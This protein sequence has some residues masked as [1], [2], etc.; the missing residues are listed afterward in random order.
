MLKE[1]LLAEAQEL[2][3]AVELDSIL[4]SV[5]LS[6]EV[7]SNFTT[8]FEQAV[9]AG[10]VKLAESHINQISERADELVE[11]QV[12]Q[13]STEIE[14][15]LYEDANKYFDHIAE[16]WLKENKEAVTRDIKADLFESMI[17][18][19]KELFVEHNVIVPEDQVDV[20]EELED[21]LAENQAEVSRL[22]ESNQAL[23]GTINSMKRESAIA[24]ATKNLSETQIEKVTSLIEGLQYS[25][26]FES[27]LGAIV[28][29]VAI[30]PEVTPV[31]EQKVPTKDDFVPIQEQKQPVS[32]SSKYVHAAKRLS[33]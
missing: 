4:E 5:Q 14:N 29:M 18:G 8:V 25:D 22:F 31:Q 27:K 26:K 15:R 23:T 28:E 19:M 10:A 17:M 2:D 33:N 7:K 16:E 3:S 30:K 9:K 32:D 12:E 13:R 20:V 11:A 21:E 6:D 1:Q 24:E